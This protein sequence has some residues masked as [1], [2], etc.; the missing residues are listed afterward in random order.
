[1]RR[2]GWECAYGCCGGRLHSAEA[3]LPDRPP[4]DYLPPPEPVYVDARKVRDLQARVDFLE[5]ALAEALGQRDRDRSRAARATEDGF[6]VVR[7]LTNA[8]P[9]Y[10]GAAIEQA[11]TILDPGA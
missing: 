1:M 8:D 2:V 5:N 4:V 11:L 7:I 9:E 10:P 3:T 6:E